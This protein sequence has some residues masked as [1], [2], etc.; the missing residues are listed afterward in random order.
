MPDPPPSPPFTTIA[1]IVAE[2]TRRWQT[3]RQA[4]DWRAVFAESYL[5]TTEQILATAGQAGAFE[6]PEWLVRLD[7][8]FAQRYFTAI[9]Y[10]D[11]G[12]D[13]PLPWYIA[14]QG[15]RE[16]RTL[17][18]QDL[19]LGMNAHIN[20]DLPYALDATI[21]P[22][23]TP[24]A[25]ASYQRDHSRMNALLA[26]TVDVVQQA[27]DYYDPLLVLA[28]Q[29]LGPGDEFGTAQLIT[30]WRARSWDHFLLLRGSADRAAADR[31]I[32]GSAHEYGLLLM[33]V[34]RAA[35][36]IYWPNRLYRDAVSLWRRR[37]S[38]KPGPP[39]PGAG[40]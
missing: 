17:V 40:A 33:Q 19:L 5:R 23:A 7:C 32:E 24:E 28:D 10:W 11:A 26:R 36:R 12:Q 1:A 18:I 14:F 22:D 9:D 39:D 4:G 31:L 6:N 37:P 3:L 25:L 8:V 29:S 2:M 13:C 16:K 35:P 34:Q 27:T 38:P 30:V 21:P 20:Y 15:N